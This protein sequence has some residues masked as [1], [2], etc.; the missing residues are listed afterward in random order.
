MTL[1]RHMRLLAVAVD[2]EFR[3]VAVFRVGFLVREVLNGVVEPLVMIAVYHAIY[4]QSTAASLGGWSYDEIVQYMLVVMFCRKVIIHNRA[5]DVSTQI[6]EGYF[7]KY[8]VMP[9]RFTVLPVARWVQYTLLQLGVA[10]ILWTIGA[11]ALPDVWPRP[12]SGV[13]AAQAL[14][15]CLIGS[16]CIF[17]M[18]LIVHLLAFWLDV[19]WSLLVMSNFITSFVS[20]AIM[21]VSQMPA[22]LRDAFVWMF[23]YWAVCAPI[24]IFLGR[25][26]TADFVRGLWVLALSL[27]ALDLL[28]RFVWARG[29]HRFAG[30]GM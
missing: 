18:H 10:G 19:V 5:L 23:P 28:R 2:Y 29:R 7:T 30:S 20:G 15:L 1:A 16:F 22:A 9:F 11:L 26:G 13:A 17:E 27:F 24:E 8:L 14:T 25:L 4:S 6:F 12:V 3:K 21:P